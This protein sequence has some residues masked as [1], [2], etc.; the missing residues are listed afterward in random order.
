M[1]S[2]TVGSK[3][4]ALIMHKDWK[5]YRIPIYL[6]FTIKDAFTNVTILFNILLC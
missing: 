1:I 2:C 4:E 3:A 5:P 6:Y